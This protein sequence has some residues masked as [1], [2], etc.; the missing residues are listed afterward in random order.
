[1][2]KSFS[3]AWLR[4]RLPG[5]ATASNALSS[6]KEKSI[7]QQSRLNKRIN[8]VPFLK[9]KDKVTFVAGVFLFLILEYLLLERPASFAAF[10]T[11]L[12]IPLLNYR[13]FSYHKS[14]YH[15]FML[16]FCYFMQ[17]FTLLLVWIWPTDVMFFKLFFGLANGPLLFAVIMWKNRVVFHD[18]DKLTSLYIHMMPPLMSHIYRYL[19]VDEPTFMF[20]QPS[21]QASLTGRDFIFM[22][23]FYMLWQFFYWIKVEVIDHDKISADPTIVTSA[24]W[25]SQYQP[26]PIYLAIKKKWSWVTPQATL[27]VT[28]LMYTGM[29]MTLIPFMYNY[30]AFHAGVLIFT[31]GVACWYGAQF[32]FDSFTENYTKRLEK[33]VDKFKNPEKYA[34]AKDLDVIGKYCPSNRSFAIFVVYI[35]T[36]VVVLL[37]AF[38]L[39]I[40]A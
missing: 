34:V 36:C 15:Y 28:Q 2:W 18:I 37:S 9:T 39:T 13:F 19:L 21:A 24:K 1:M 32:Y 23:F 27:I 35:V 33:I 5:I 16:D 22:I 7:E 20:R 4:E 10:Y 12:T 40:W 14:N 3:T 25:L 38:K 31:F 30:Q 26:H 8:Q 6:L 11:L 17:V 29:T